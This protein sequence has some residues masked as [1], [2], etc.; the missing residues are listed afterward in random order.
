VPRNKEKHGKNPA[1][2]G[3]NE[4]HILN[5]ES[6]SPELLE[7]AIHELPTK[8]SP[9]SAVFTTTIIMAT[10]SAVFSPVIGNPINPTTT[11][12][13]GNLATTTGQLDR[14][15]NQVQDLRTPRHCRLSGLSCQFQEGQPWSSRLRSKEATTLGL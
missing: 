15:L 2:K 6:V 10:I 1:R 9:N 11:A 5:A 8:S 3:V 4:H 13:S 14:D 7:T 12:N